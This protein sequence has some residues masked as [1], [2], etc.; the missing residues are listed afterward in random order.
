MAKF[1]S[2]GAVNGTVFNL[3]GA[4]IRGRSK[5]PARCRVICFS[6][7]PDD[8][9]ISMGGILRKL[10]ENENDNDKRIDADEF[11]LVRVERSG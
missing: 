10:V 3:L 6:P 11:S 1:G 4:K 8:D 2:P 5:L 9:V 7:H